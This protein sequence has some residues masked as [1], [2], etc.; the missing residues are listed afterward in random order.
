[1]PQVSRLEVIT[2]G[3]RRRWTS[4]E[5]RRLVAESYAV[6]RGASATARRH[7]LTISQL[8]GWR[9]LAREGRLGGGE[10]CGFAAA[11]IV[12]DGSAMRSDPG[13]G[14]GRME[15]SVGDARIAVDAGV[16]AAALA[17]V[18]EVLSRSAGSRRE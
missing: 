17:R 11:M 2:T 6:P 3:A 13:L 5:K 16:D 1:M 18:L 10:E 14:A 9:K 15:I 12:P 7:G 8:F 4:A